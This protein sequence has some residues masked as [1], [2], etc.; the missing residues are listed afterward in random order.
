MPESRRSADNERQ[1]GKMI[2]RRYL[3]G[4]GYLDCLITA[5]PGGDQHGVGFAIRQT[6]N[7]ILLGGSGIE[8]AGARRA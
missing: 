1:I 6:A 5:I 8:G 2:D 3:K 4:V 7:I